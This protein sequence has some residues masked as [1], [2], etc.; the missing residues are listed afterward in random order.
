MGP[1]R[2]VRP[3]PD[4]V[5]T[6]TRAFFAADLA[7]LPVLDVMGSEPPASESDDMSSAWSEFITLTRSEVYQATGVLIAQLGVTPAEALARLRAH[8]F[9]NGKT[10]SDT[11]YDILEHRLL[12]DDDRTGN[13]GP[14]YGHHYPAP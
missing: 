13:D 4:Q 7:A 14:E 2:T 3:G 1:R 12:L 6:A 11:A 8:A 9:A 10:A 5:D